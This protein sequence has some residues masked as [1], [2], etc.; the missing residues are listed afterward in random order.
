MSFARLRGALRASVSLAQM[1]DDPVT[2][3]ALKSFR[4][5]D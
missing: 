4:D 1:D 3:G 5:P 2:P